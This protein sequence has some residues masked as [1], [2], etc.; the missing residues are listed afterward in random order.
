[1]HRPT[2]ATSD[3]ILLAGHRRLAVHEPRAAVVLAHGF[4]ASAEDPAVSA[5]ADALNAAGYDVVTYDA[6]GHGGSEG[7]STL[8]DLEQHDVA[9]AVAATRERTDRLV[10]VGAS[11]GAIAALRF[12]ANHEELVDGVISLSSPAQWR[13]PRTPT[14]ILSAGLTRTPMGRHLARRFLR[15]RI[16]SK[17]TAPQPP[18]ELVAR[19]RS[20]LAV[21]HGR[22]DRFI[23]PR[24]AEELFAAAGDPRRLSIVDEMGHAFDDA[25]APAVLEAIE[26]AL[27][28]APRSRGALV[29]AS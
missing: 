2:F 15:V 28:T 24:A 5:M 13:L 9:A 20:P 11:M 25:A 22:R 3:D 7:E 4:C 29:G 18:V 23:P 19:I 12:A 21:I 16:A 14:A 27:D 1:M 10:V 17:W 26:W 6:R 8:G